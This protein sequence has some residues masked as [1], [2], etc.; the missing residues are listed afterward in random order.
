[1]ASFL[2]RPTTGRS[3]AFQIEVYDHG[4]ASLR[5]REVRSRTPFQP[6]SVPSNIDFVPDSA[7]TYSELL[8]DSRHR[9]WAR[10]P[11]SP[12]ETEWRVFDVDGTSI[13][14]LRLPED[15]SVLDANESRLLLLRRD[16]FDLESIEV[17]ELAW[18]AP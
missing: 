17:W 10:A 14:S 11:V 18:S 15:A 8:V 4:A 12:R 3:S 16:E 7:P 13:G 6:D 1:M 9:I 5:I 2:V